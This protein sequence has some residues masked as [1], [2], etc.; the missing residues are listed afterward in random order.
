MKIFLVV[1]CF[2][3]LFITVSAQA[4]VLV[5]AT[6]S[7]LNKSSTRINSDIT[8]ET[9]RSRTLA[10]GKTISRLR[11]TYQGI[12]I[13]GKS[14]TRSG[15]GLAAKLYGDVVIGLKSE[16]PSVRPMVEATGAMERAMLHSIEQRARQ[17]RIQGTF[18]V[19][20]LK[21]VAKNQ[22][23]QRYIYIDTQNR[24]RLSYLVNWVEHGSQ[25]SRP[26]YFIDA[27]NGEIL[28]Y[29]E[30]M[31]HLEATG[32]G[33]NE[34][35]GRYFYG[36]DFP[37]MQVDSDCRMDTPNVETI[38]LNG[39]QEGGRVFQFTCPHNDYKQINGAYSPLNDAH[40][41]GNIVINMYRDW[42][43]ITPLPGKMQLGVHYGENLDNAI[44]DGTRANFGDG[45]TEFYPLV[46]LDMV[47]H[48]I[49]HG[50]T[51]Q[52][53]NLQYSHQPGG[54]NESFS[55]ISGEAA[56]FY[57]RG[58]ND[59]LV[60]A[61][62]K[63]D[64][65]ALRYFADPTLDG[66]SIDHASDFRSGLDV[67]FSSG[68]F[69]RAF[70][71]I[72]TASGW[73]TKKAFDIFLLANQMYWVPNSDFVLGACG[74]RFA[75]LDLGYDLATVTEA[76][77]TVGVSTDNCIELTPPAKPLANNVPERELSAGA[78]EFLY[79][80]LKVPEGA[81]ELKFKLTHGSGAVGLA[82][83]LHDE[84]ICSIQPS[85]EICEISDAEQGTYEVILI[86]FTDFSGKTLVGSFN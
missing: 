49:S 35:T 61:E 73:N 79:Y 7:L 58:T 64:R 67:H 50:F 12:P 18:S 14:I 33:G 2:L 82:V 40:F 19:P 43:N 22:K 59:W 54:I 53:S 11:Q 84:G 62:I 29:W 72:A 74:V 83:A 81:T 6:P 55:D 16:L 71:L 63:K 4:V 86:A 75:T 69:N 51:E 25:P 42:Y 45:A 77:D 9:V 68:V 10:N 46:S 65:E 5:P 48:E 39:G 23:Q 1:K 47:T 32:P 15:E 28:E 30:G 24:A 85:D 21:L 3:L 80:F 52:N 36:T 8:L 56:E 26:F 27:L 34:K 41:N 31:N 44:W 60:G 20:T 13:W 37:P 17:G 70:Y 38:D 57:F 66:K 78:G 76:F